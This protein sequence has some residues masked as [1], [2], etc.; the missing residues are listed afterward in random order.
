MNV[1]PYS[2]PI[3][4]TDDI[5]QQYGGVF[6]SS[7]PEMRQAVYTIAEELATDDI[8]TF[9]LPTLV[10]GTQVYNHSHSPYLTEYSYVNQVILVR[11]LDTE[12]DIYYSISGTANVYA[13]LRND[14]YGIVD[15][16]SI[17]GNCHCVTSLQPFPY[18]VQIVY[19]AGL[20]TGTANN[21]RNLM[22]LTSIADMVLNE[23]E[24]FGNEAAG[25]VGV[26]RFKNQDY[27]EMRHNLKNTAF[28]SSA[29]SQFVSN[30]LTPLR[31]HRYVKLF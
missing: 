13:S 22:A 10:T 11:F 12:E 26:D 8:G 5:F 23:M 14:T 15:I 6:G 4:L 20:P 9:L 30:L 16:H 31:K 29:R 21:P 1:Y 27:F 19:E 17:F 24:G 25:L 18:Q 28:G 2:I 7:T 3:I